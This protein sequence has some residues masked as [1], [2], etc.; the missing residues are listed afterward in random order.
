ML[1]QSFLS[2]F[3]FCESQISVAQ[4]M[5]LRISRHS[6]LTLSLITMELDVYTHSCDVTERV[7]WRL[8]WRSR[9]QDCYKLRLPHSTGEF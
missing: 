3:L 1:P 4:A 9:C 7:R 8:R 2:R 5:R 6:V